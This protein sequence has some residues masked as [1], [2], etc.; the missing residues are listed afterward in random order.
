MT[1]GFGLD[2]GKAAHVGAFALGGPIPVPLI[3]VSN[4][5]NTWLLG[6][7]NLAYSSTPD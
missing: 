5:V 2:L 7:R 4:K 3:V 1:T 6:I